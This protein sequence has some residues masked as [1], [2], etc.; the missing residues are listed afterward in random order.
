MNSD[1]IV[2]MVE[3]VARRKL[4]IDVFDLPNPKQ[5]AHAYFYFE[6]IRSWW[7]KMQSFGE[8]TLIFQLHFYRMS[9]L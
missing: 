4:H 8:F 6:V 9:F 2:E 7:H 3:C 5:A 1:L